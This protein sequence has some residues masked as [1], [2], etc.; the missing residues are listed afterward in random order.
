MPPL[1]DTSLEDSNS[2]PEPEVLALEI[3]A[4]LQAT[5]EVSPGSLPTWR[6]ETFLKRLESNPVGRLSQQESRMLKLWRRKRH[7]IQN[8]VRY[9]STI[10]TPSC[11]PTASLRLRLCCHRRSSSFDEKLH[12]I[13]ALIFL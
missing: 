8:E 3:A 5:M 13:P 1:R 6:S 2:L 7:V 10:A 4:D 11:N 9:R 12:Q